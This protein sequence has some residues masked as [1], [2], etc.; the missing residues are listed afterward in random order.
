MWPIRGLATVLNRCVC[1][2]VHAC[3]RACVRVCVCVHVRVR[4]CMCV[5]ARA[6]VCNA[7]MCS[8][9]AQ[10]DSVSNRG[11]CWSVVTIGCLLPEGVTDDRTVV[12][13]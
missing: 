1:V 6:C 12:H 8:L 13:W 5:C 10:C 11:R 2:C 9:I 4:V 3:V 7:C